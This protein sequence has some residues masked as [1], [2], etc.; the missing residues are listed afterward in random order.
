MKPAYSL[1]M[2]AVLVAMSSPA[3]GSQPAEPTESAI[4]D[5]D[6]ENWAF[7]SLQRPHIPQ[8]HGDSRAVN[9]VDRFLEVE[10]QT[11]QLE[12]APEADRRTLLRRLTLDLWGMPPTREEIIA[13]ECDG[14]SD[15]YEQV[16]ERLLSSPRYGEHTAQAW[17]DLARFAETDGFEHDQVRPVAYRY[18]DWVIAAFN[19][20]MPYDRFVQ[21]QLAGDLIEPDA[22]GTHIATAFCV[23]GPDMPDLN[24]QQERKHRLL[25]EMT[26]TIGSVLLGLTIGCAECHDHKYDSISQADFYRLRA[27]FTKSLHVDANKPVTTLRLNDNDDGKAFNYLMIRGDWQRPGNAVNPGFVRVANLSQRQP[28]PAEP[29]LARRELA[30]WMT[31]ADAN[32][33]AVRVIVNRVW[34][35]HFGKGLV[36]TSSDFGSMGFEPSNAELLDWL[37]SEFVTQRWSLK[38]LHRL[39]VTSAAYRQASR[40]ADESE[41][42]S[43]SWF[44]RRELDPKAEYLSFFPRRRMAAEVIRDSLFAVS[45]SLHP[46]QGGPG[47][48]PPLPRE[49]VST[50]IKGQWEPSRKSEDALRRSIY[51]FARRN[52]RY[53]LFAEF[54]RP[55]ANS[56]CAARGVSTTATQSLYLLNSDVAYDAARR[57][58]E[59]VLSGASRDERGILDDVAWR[60]F[61]RPAKSHEQDRW[62]QFLQK[63][64]SLVQEENSSRQ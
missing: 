11:R 51:I 9:V 4:S 59:R 30:E 36:Q 54:D 37:A 12:F 21:L 22:Q 35:S 26:G 23:S 34:Q 1:T 40:P 55:A 7:R 29:R 5:V 56:S 31:D 33:L 14:R 39:L 52:L 8:R 13:F 25:N 63:Q 6:R 18:R 38:H 58:A 42:A 62:S 64:R 19:S 28:N 16:V 27:F 32:P 43:Q 17:L 24:S 48:R 50:L 45:D 44:A 46:Q 3:C 15:A 60:V 20:D 61:G 10:L 47:V 53:P 57:L 41:Q 2:I 49:L